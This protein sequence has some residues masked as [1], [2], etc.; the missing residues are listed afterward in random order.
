MRELEKSQGG[1]TE[2]RRGRGGRERESPEKNIDIKKVLRGFNNIVL[3][4]RDS[5]LPGFRG[6]SA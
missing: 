4:L 2:R 5:C 3:N 6:G 1:E